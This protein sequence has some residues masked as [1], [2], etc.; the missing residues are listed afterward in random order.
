[1]YYPVDRDT[2]TDPPDFTKLVKYL[3][4]D[5]VVSGTVIT[6]G[7]TRAVVIDSVAE[8]TPNETIS[9]GDKK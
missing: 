7:R 6:R 1:M 5:V 2:M 4:Q 8:Y 3:E 9:P